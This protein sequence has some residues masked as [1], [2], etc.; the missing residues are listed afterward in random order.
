MAGAPYRRSAR[1]AAVMGRCSPSCCDSRPSRDRAAANFGA[2]LQPLRGGLLGGSRP[3]TRRS[4]RAVNRGKMRGC[5][6]PRGQEVIFAARAGPPDPARGLP[7]VMYAAPRLAGACAS[8]RLLAAARDRRRPRARRFL[9]R[10][11]PPPVPTRLRQHA[12]RDPRAL[13]TDV[14][15]ALRHRRGM[16][17]VMASG[18]A[19]FE[20]GEHDGVDPAGAPRVALPA[21][22]GGGASRRGGD[23]GQRIRRRGALRDLPVLRRSAGLGA[24]QRP[25]GRGDTGATQGAG[26]R[27]SGGVDPRGGDR[28]G[29]RP[30][31]ARLPTAATGGR[32]RH[33]RRASR[34]SSPGCAA[35]RMP[36][37]CLT[38]VAGLAQA[39]F[40]VCAR[41]RPPHI[42][43]DRRH[44]MDRF[45]HSR[46]RAGLAS[47]RPRRRA[48][49]GGADLGQRAAP[50]G[51]PAGHLGRRARSRARSRAAASRGRWWSRRS[52]RS[53]PARP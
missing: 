28:P 32:G 53:R 20:E 49:H 47:R 24:A 35:H 42:A 50:G 8:H 17:G 44:R 25:S 19:G 4:A 43:A 6:R 41:A 27:P 26:G 13:R 36:R 29:W 48:G 45:G 38:G 37:K 2:R 30:M 9:D 18:W 1:C 10:I 51:Q 16:R 23:H 46:N 52:T 3:P 14:T 40:G 15:E 39:R 22:G 34:R 11:G 12:E 31:R 21:H 7:A 5:R 33:R